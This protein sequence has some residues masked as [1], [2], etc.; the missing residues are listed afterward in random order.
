MTGLDLVRHNWGRK[1]D[2]ND[3]EAG[4]Y[5]FEIIVLQRFGILPYAGALYDQ[6]PIFVDE[7]R[8]FMS[9]LAAH[10]KKHSPKT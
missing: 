4:R 6:D 2:G 10:E 5:D 8:E 3:V 7:L 1:L 9:A